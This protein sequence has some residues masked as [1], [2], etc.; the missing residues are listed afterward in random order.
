M[1]SAIAVISTLS[2]QCEHLMTGN[3]LALPMLLSRDSNSD[4]AS[5]LLRLGLRISFSFLGL[6]SFRSECTVYCSMAGRSSFLGK[7]SIDRVARKHGS[8]KATVRKFSTQSRVSKTRV[9]SSCSLVYFDKR[10]DRNIASNE[11]MPGRRRT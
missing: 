5:F 7:S 4:R 10:D 2:P 9:C 1:C 6:E 8:V 11:T 3:K